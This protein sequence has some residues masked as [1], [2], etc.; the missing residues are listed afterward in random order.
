MRVSV[1]GRVAIVVDSAASLPADTAER[2]GLFVVPMQLAVGDETYLDG[3]D[4]K[5]TAFYRM[6]RDMTDLPK[7]SAPSPASFLETFRSAAKGAAAIFCLTVSSRFSSSHDSARTAVREAEGAVQHT[8]IAVVDSGSAAG[9]EGLIA[10]EAWRAAQRGESLDGVV[11]AAE[12]VIPKVSIL[13]YVDTLHYLWKGGRVQRLAYAG[14]SLLRIKPVFELSQG[15][16]RNVARPRT[17]RRAAERLVEL[18]RRRVGSGRLHATVMHADVEEAAE[19]LQQRIGAEFPCDELY[20][21]EFSP[22]MG[23]HTGPG[24]LGV[25]FWSEGH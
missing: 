17:G 25:A 13:A 7:T 16:V 3:R 14:T 21:S 6:L 5:P 9:G 12:A 22:V 20:V 2:E 4:L 11:A 19:A 23:A 1:R 24:L 15:E 8:E 18:M 10:L